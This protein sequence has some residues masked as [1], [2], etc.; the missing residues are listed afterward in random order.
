MPS[1]A[2]SLASPIDRNG[3]GVS[4]GHKSSR[5]ARSSRV[6]PAYIREGELRA[7][8]HRI[9]LSCPASIRPPSCGR[10]VMCDRLSLRSWSVFGNLDLEYVSS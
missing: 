6:G 4:A 7:L 9:R 2:E 10:A 3:G 1:G 5:F 8:M